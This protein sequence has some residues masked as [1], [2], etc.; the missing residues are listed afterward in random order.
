VITRTKAPKKLAAPLLPCGV[1]HNTF[2]HYMGNSKK[3]GPLVTELAIRNLWVR[4]FILLLNVYSRNTDTPHITQFET[5]M[6]K[7]LFL[8]RGP[9]LVPC[10][11]PWDLW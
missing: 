3:P 4:W 10:H 1:Q 5:M 8:R 6:V 7:H 2:S 11:S 9:G